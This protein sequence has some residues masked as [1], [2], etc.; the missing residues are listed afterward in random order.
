MNSRPPVFNVP[1]CVVV[2]LGLIVAVHLVRLLLNEDNDLVLL[3]TLAFIPARYGGGVPSLPGGGVADVTS[4]V[5][6]MFVHG[7]PMHLLVNGV[8]MLAFGSAIARRIGDFRFALFSVLCGIAGAVSHLALHFGELAPVVGASAAI[9]G[10]MAGAIRFLLGTGG[11]AFGGDQRMI[12][13]VPLASVTQT[14]SNPRILIFIGV[15]AA[16]N[17]LFGTGL[18]QFQGASGGIAWEA[19]IGGFVCG[20]LIFGLFDRP[21]ALE[22][23]PG[24]ADGGGPRRLH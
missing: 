20:L 4:F 23:A 6:Y 3:L 1:R 14:L 18:L 17:A 2:A 7:D 15:W 9:S 21:P 5:T 8:W 10:Q 13:L 16:L 24:P 12:R 11:R 22:P 19:H